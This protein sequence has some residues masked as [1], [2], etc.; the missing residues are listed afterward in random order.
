[1]RCCP[2]PP[3]QGRRRPGPAPASSTYPYLARVRRWHEADA[4]DSPSASPA[5]VAVI[6]PRAT[7][8]CSSASRTGCASARMVRASFTCRVGIVT[9]PTLALERTLSQGLFRLLAA[10]GV[11]ARRAVLHEEHAAVQRPVAD[12]LEIDG[13]RAVERG[14][15][16]GGPR[17]QRED[18]PTRTHD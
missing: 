9:R 10:R 8:S 1:M 17:H 2:P 5:S 12:Q 13:D 15:P 16:P 14:P 11:P 7:R 3:L 4:G 6:G 18:P